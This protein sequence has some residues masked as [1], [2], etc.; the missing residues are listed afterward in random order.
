MGDSTRTREGREVGN[1]KEDSPQGKARWRKR[2][3][4]IDRGGGGAKADI[5]APA[6]TR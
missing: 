3:E 6:P 1:E 2:E 5:R 4:A